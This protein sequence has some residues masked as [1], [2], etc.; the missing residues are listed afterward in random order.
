MTTV[1]Y[2][3][4]A[5]W[6]GVW[7]GTP[8]TE[9][10]LDAETFLHHVGAPNQAWAPEDAF[11][12][13]RQ[14][15][16]YAQNT[17]GYQFLD[18]DVLTHYSRRDDLI[19]IAEGRGRY[20]SAATLDRNEQG[21]AVLFCGNYSLRPPLP[22]EL[23]AGALGVV[24]GIKQGW[25]AVNSIIMGHRDNPVH[26]G[27]TSCPGSQFTEAHEQIVRDRVKQL[28]GAP[29]PTPDPLPTTGIY[30]VK[31]GD[32]WWR[33]G[34]NTGVAMNTLILAN[35][36]PLHPLMVLNKPGGGTI[37]VQAGEGW[38]SL[39]RRANTTMNEMILR[40]PMPL[41]PGMQIKIPTQTVALRTA[42]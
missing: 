23:E 24:Y 27:A 21:E 2:A 6:G 22:Q 5:Q 19:T 31:S 33:V 39:A 16:T 15:N 40:N 11:P 10:L 34:Q 7:L 18:Y 25:I 28:L 35:P 38:W 3:T 1:R 12:Y 8:S 36:M 37:V 32:G 29:A 4:A 41:H 17:K 9:A 20:R 13:F 30:V 14:L 42:A 26:V